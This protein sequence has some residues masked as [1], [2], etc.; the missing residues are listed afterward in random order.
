MTVTVHVLALLK[1]AVE[2]DPY[3]HLASLMAVSSTH[4]PAGVEAGVLT[5]VDGEITATA[6]GRR[7]YTEHGLGL[8]PPGRANNWLAVC[9]EIVG[10]ALAGLGGTR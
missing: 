9:P 5:V 1:G 10:A 4:L 2:G 3:R 7:F 6:A 8:L